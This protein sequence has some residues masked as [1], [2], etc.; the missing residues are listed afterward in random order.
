[1]KIEIR[2]EIGISMFSYAALKKWQRLAA[3][4]PSYRAKC[5]ADMER[6]FSTKCN[7]LRCYGETVMSRYT[8]VLRKIDS[9]SCKRAARNSVGKDSGGK[10]TGLHCVY[11][12]K[13]N[14]IQTGS[15]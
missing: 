7:V 9:C 12:Q 5:I 2:P 10:C 1:M 6:K 8:I 13:D 14:R 3:W 11:R 4:F 15:L